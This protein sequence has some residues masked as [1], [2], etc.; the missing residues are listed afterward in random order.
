MWW[1][2]YRSGYVGWPACINCSFANHCYETSYPNSVLEFSSEVLLPNIW[3]AHQIN[4]FTNFKFQIFLRIIVV[5]SGKLESKNLFWTN[6][7]FLFFFNCSNREKFQLKWWNKLVKTSEEFVGYEME[8][9]KLLKRTEIMF[10]LEPNF[11]RLSFVKILLGMIQIPRQTLL[12][13]WLKTWTKSR[14]ALERKWACLLD[15]LLPF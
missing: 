10:E 13:K 7:K 4:S 8:Q 2:C 14:M 6:K 9:I 1:T 5:I 3:R 12:V 11:W 15:S